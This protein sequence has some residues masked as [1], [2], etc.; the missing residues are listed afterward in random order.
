MPS[1]ELEAKMEPDFLD[2]LRVF[3]EL[4]EE[5]SD[6][7]IAL[8]EEQSDGLAGLL[9]DCIF[10]I[11]QQQKLRDRL[12]AENARLK[13]ALEKSIKLQS[14]YAKL[15]NAYDGG[16]RIVFSYQEWLDRLSHLE[17]VANADRDD[18][19]GVIFADG[20]Y[21]WVEDGN[22]LAGPFDDLGEAHGEG[23]R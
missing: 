18:H 14:H 20:K 2:K 3:V 4:F 21:W 9:R 16:K 12:R 8:G 7:R 6:A 11:S 5:A 23:A 13:E 19:N 10:V 15:L 1:D 22:I 17:A